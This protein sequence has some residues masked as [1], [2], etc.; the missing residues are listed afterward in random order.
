MTGGVMSMLMRG[1][2]RRRIVGFGVTSIDRSLA[3][4][5]Q[6]NGHGRLCVRA[7]KPRVVWQEAIQNRRL[8][9]QRFPFGEVRPTLSEHPK[10]TL[11]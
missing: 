2:C 3:L 7:V 4:T 5:M 10:R 6:V 11:D 9:T 8:Q 1:R